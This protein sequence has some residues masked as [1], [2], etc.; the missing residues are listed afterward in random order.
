[1][2]ILPAFWARV[3][4]FNSVALTFGTQAIEIIGFFGGGCLNVALFLATIVNKV[5]SK[6]R[7]SVPAPFR[8]ALGPEAD[9]GLILFRAHSHECLEGF[10]YSYM[11]ELSERLDQFDMF[12]AE[13]DDLATAVF[14]DAVQAA[15]DGD[16]R[17]VLPAPL[18]QHAR[19]DGEAAFVGM[20]K[21]FQIWNPAT[22][23]KRRNQARERVKSQGLTLPRDKNT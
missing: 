1:M 12:S 2:D 6:G 9:H 5:D 18:I 16:G 22:F 23:D 13:Q 4:S 21:K 19:I 11:K 15:I 14:G 20:G 17:I 10:A 8:A 3:H 7:V